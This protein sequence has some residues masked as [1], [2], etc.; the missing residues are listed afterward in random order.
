MTDSDIN[1]NVGDV[2]KDRYRLV[3]NISKGFHRVIFFALNQ[4]M[5]QVAIK[6][7]KDMEE[8]T[9]VC[10]EAA[11]LKILGNQNHIPKFFQYGSHKNCKFLAQELL[12]PNMVE[13]VNYKKPNKFSLHSMLKFGIQAIETL[14][15]IHNKGFVHRDIK[16]GNFL[17]GNK[18]STIGTFY[19]TDF[20][21]CKKLNQKNGVLVKPTAKGSFRGAKMYAS[22]NAHHHVEMGRQDDLMS[23]LYILVEFYNGMLPW[24]EKDDMVKIQTLKF[25][26]HGHKLLKRLPKQFIEFETHISSLDYIQK[27]DYEYLISLLKDAAKENNIDLNAPFDWEEDMNEERM[28]IM[29]HHVLFAQKTQIIVEK[30]EMEK[31]QIQ[32]QDSE[33]KSEQIQQL[34]REI[35]EQQ[36]LTL[37]QPQLEMK[38]NAMNL[39]RR[40]LKKSD[41]QTEDGEQKEYQNEA[42]EDIQPTK[43]GK[44][45]PQSTSHIHNVKSIQ[46]NSQPS[47]QSSPILQ[48]QSQ[49]NISSQTQLLLKKSSSDDLIQH[50]LLFTPNNP[51]LQ[52]RSTSPYQHTRQRSDTIQ[53]FQEMLDNLIGLDVEISQM[54][55]FEVTMHNESSLKPEKDPFF[56]EFMDEMT[57]LDEN[58]SEMDL[59]YFVA[60]NEGKHGNQGNDVFD[61]QNSDDIFSGNSNNRSNIPNQNIRGRSESLF[62]TNDFDFGVSDNLVTP[63]G[64]VKQQYNNIV[65]PE[66]RLSIEILEQVLHPI[67]DVIHNPT[68]TSQK[69]NHSINAN[70]HK[71]HSGKY[72]NRSKMQELDPVPNTPMGAELMKELTEWDLDDEQMYEELS[73]L[74]SEQW[75]DKDDI[76]HGLPSDRMDDIDDEDNDNNH[77]CIFHESSNPTPLIS[78]NISTITKRRKSLQKPKDPNLERLNVQLDEGLTQQKSEQIDAEQK[79]FEQV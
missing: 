36:Q 47:P 28:K 42:E 26:Y 57:K 56:E 70:K 67:T 13:L 62:A 74:Q 37:T 10:V 60:Q 77:A 12:G 52:S 48:S 75:K 40:L 5:Q 25:H 43:K 72:S 27:P 7:E 50:Q 35:N 45:A 14:Q 78:M 33:N 23:L 9:A 53:E 58:S 61:I 17:I 11:V 16:P 73:N 54:K 1:I 8:Q 55:S 18:R 68:N 59:A 63:K 38:L 49:Q 69:I 30:L 39:I 24:S 32:E 21:L 79:Q 66:R 19:L 29:R 2:I 3:K 6:L 4:L 31:K 41:E 15:I 44:Q 64:A 71:H 34:D 76:M 46:Y 51:N 20:S 65:N 22:L